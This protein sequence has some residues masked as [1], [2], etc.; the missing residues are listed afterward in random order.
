MIVSR[1]F[2]CQP[3]PG[4]HHSRGLYGSG[5]TLCRL[6]QFRCLRLPLRVCQDLHEDHVLRWYSSCC[7][8]FYL[9]ML[10]PVSLIG[11][12]IGLKRLP[13]LGK[14]LCCLADLYMMIWRLWFLIFPLCSVF[15]CLSTCVLVPL[16]DRLLQSA[17]LSFN[18][19][20]GYVHGDV[21]YREPEGP[22][23]LSLLPQANR[24]RNELR[25]PHGSSH[26][27]GPAVLGRG[28]VRYQSTKS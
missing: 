23:A 18:D 12:K 4:L 28:Q 3:S 17:D 25:L 20:A 6:R 5:L 2:F 9:C 21:R 10:N 7:K 8:C 11:C 19:P 14:L 15:L 1:H 27:S 13:Q 22:A 16:A 26:G 24:R